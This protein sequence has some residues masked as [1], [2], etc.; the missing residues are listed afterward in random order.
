MSSNTSPALSSK[1]SNAPK[2]TN[3]PSQLS[4]AHS[5]ANTSFAAEGLGQR[6]SGG[7]CSSGIAAANSKAASTPRSNQTAKSKHKQSRKFRLADED[8]LAESVSALD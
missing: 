6:R 7:Y 1:L 5:A 3:T 2:S 4:P 8:A